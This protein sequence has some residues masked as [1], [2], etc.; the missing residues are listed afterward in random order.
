MKEDESK[1]MITA[2]EFK[3]NLGLY[4]DS[5][6]GGQEVVITKN[7]K[8]AARLLSFNSVQAPPRTLLEE[9]VDYKISPKTVPY[10]EFLKIYEN[11]DARMEYI[12]GEIIMLGSPNVAHQTISGTLYLILSAYLKGK[13]CRVFYAPFDVHLYKINIKDPDVVQP[14]LLIACDIEEKVDSRGR[15]TGIPALVIEILSPGTRTK[16]MVHKLNTYMLSGVREFWV[17]DP[18]NRGVFVYGFNNYEIDHFAVYKPGDTI[19]SH[20]FD[21]LECTPD[22]LF[23][24]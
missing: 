4:L 8:I 6:I 13:K 17:V 3:N 7:G 5:A 15:Y 9:A 20:F 11:T 1:T 18:D 2:T 24:V 10:E 19:Q 23:T 14:D 12:N 22:E 21:G 16:D